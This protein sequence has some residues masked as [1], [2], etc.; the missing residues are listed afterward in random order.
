MGLDSTTPLVILSDHG[1]SLLVIRYLRLQ[2][3]GSGATRKRVMINTQSIV[4]KESYNHSA[5]YCNGYVM[6]SLKYER[7]YRSV[8]KWFLYMLSFRS[9]NVLK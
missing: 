8:I 3:C 7:S 4:D 1:S 9:T 2:L 5:D 6:E